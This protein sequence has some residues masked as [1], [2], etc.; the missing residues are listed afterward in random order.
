VTAASTTLEYQRKKVID[1]FYPLLLLYRLA[2]Y[3]KIGQGKTIQTNEAI[4]KKSQLPLRVLI[5][6]LALLHK[7]I[8]ALDRNPNRLLLIFNVLVK[9]P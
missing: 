2:L 6:A 3:K 7:N 1:L 5:S 4:A 9:L 8:E